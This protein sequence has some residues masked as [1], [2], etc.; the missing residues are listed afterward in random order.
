MD[1]KINAGSWVP[2]PISSAQQRKKSG[3][4]TPFSVLLHSTDAAAQVSS[5]REAADFSGRTAAEV[6]EQ[7]LADRSHPDLDSLDDYM[8]WLIQQKL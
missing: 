7:A 3:V 2:K 5:A 8:E 4:E 6:F 1:V